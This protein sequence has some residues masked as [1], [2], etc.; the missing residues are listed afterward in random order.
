MKIIDFEDIRGLHIPPEMC[1]QWVDG[2]I[3]DKKQVILP[4]KSSLKPMD[5]V[6]CNVMPSILPRSDLWAG[7]VKVV[8]RYPDRQPSLHP[9][10]GQ[11][12][13]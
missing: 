8:T 13:V 11:N 4:P 6:F 3:K 9:P 1:Y 12:R 7:G 10:A 2:M 5:G